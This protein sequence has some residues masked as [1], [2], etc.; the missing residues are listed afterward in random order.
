LRGRGQE[1]L[2]ALLADID[3]PRPSKVI[4]ARKKLNDGDSTASSGI[5]QINQRRK[6]YGLKAL[7]AA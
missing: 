5:Q 1:G 6:V 3:D 4:D 7:K 2:N